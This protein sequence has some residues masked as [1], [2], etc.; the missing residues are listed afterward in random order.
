[1][2]GEAKYDN[3]GS[4]NKVI[5]YDGGN[6]SSYF[7]PIDGDL[8]ALRQELDQDISNASKHFW[9]L[10]VLSAHFLKQDSDQSVLVIGRA[11]N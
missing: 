8:S 6:H 1:M 11:G 9:M 2:L 10:P 7:W 4:D 5:Q 3:E